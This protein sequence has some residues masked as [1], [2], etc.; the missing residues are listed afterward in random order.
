MPKAATILSRNGTDAE[1]LALCAEFHHRYEA[2]FNDPPGLD[3]EAC[4]AACRALRTVVDQVNNLVPATLHGHAAK[5]RVAVVLLEEA[6]D[7]APDGTA[8]HFALWC[9]RDLVD[10]L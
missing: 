4:N 10:A 5:A 9:L 1:L 3:D 8:E 6:H 2:A 7:G